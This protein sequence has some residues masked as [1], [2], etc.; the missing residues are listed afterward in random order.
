M[1]MTTICA[2]IVRIAAAMRRALMK[3]FDMLIRN[4]AP[5]GGV[6]LHGYYFRELSRFA[7]FAFAF[8]SGRCSRRSCPSGGAGSRPA[9][10][11]GRLQGARR[12]PR[13][14]ARSARPRLR[15]S[16][17]RQRERRI[18][19]SWPSRARSDRGNVVDRRPL[20]GRLCT[21]AAA[22]RHRHRRMEHAGPRCCCFGT[23]TRRD[24]RARPLTGGR[25][26]IWRG[27]CRGRRSWPPRW[28][29]P[30]EASAPPAPAS[31]ET[32]PRSARPRRVTMSSAAGIRARR[33]I[34][35]DRLCARS[36]PLCGR[37]CHPF[38]D[39]IRAPSWSSLHVGLAH[40]SPEQ[41]LPTAP[42]T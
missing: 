4:G 12:P 10:R 39:Q 38:Q 35:A 9:S 18:S 28:Q 40:A 41:G 17:P 13:P 19:A 36:S 42:P 15:P 1:Q 21:P 8:R 6:L 20:K 2:T 23:T 34:Q 27:L 24:L 37:R 3:N 25:G 33:V 5:E 22:M 32:A 31:V 16:P 29:P 7:R 30:S 26:R 11:D 14:S